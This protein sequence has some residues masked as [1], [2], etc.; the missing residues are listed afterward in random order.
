MTMIST[1]TTTTTMSM[2]TTTTTRGMI[3][4]HLIR[5]RGRA[6]RML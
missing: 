6:S 1:M 2:M 5:M 4:A 3:M